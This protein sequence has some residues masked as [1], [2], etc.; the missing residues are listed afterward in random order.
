MNKIQKIL[1]PVDFSEGS[2][3]SLEYAAS[4]ARETGSELIVRF[5]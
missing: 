5:C 2:A 4:L 3:N 1:A